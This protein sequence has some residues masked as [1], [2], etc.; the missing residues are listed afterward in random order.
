MKKFQLLQKIGKIDIYFGSGENQA[1]STEEEI[2]LQS[3]GNPQ[4][5]YNNHQSASLTS[6][7]Q[8]IETRLSK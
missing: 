7:H 8:Q 1:L 6:R 5:C 3:E 4:R 2:E